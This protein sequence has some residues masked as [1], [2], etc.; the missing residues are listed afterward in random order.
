MKILTYLG[1]IGFVFFLIGDNSVGHFL[2]GF[3]QTLL[4]DHLL[5]KEILKL[6]SFMFAVLFI[7]EFTLIILK[8]DLWPISETIQFI[9]FGVLTALSSSASG[10]GN[11]IFL[12]SIGTMF[13]IQIFTSFI[14]K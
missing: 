9:I 11:T 13:V 2:T 5:L 3:F 7:V 10:N 8:D 1:Y 4:K 6:S 12:V 14:K